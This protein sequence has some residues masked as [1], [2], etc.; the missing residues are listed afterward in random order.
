MSKRSPFVSMMLGAGVFFLMSS[1]GA[2]AQVQ[3]TDQQ[4][5]LNAVNKDGAAVA[6]TQ[7]KENVGCVR[8]AGK[9]TLTGTAQACL[10]A[11]AKGKVGKAKGKTSA[12]AGNRAARR[13]TSASRAGAR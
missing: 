8:G 9:G 6:K 7:G 12:D 13:R 11:D 3:S 5:C 4:K 1:V 10:T 2:Y